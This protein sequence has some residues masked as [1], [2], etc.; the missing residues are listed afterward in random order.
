MSLRKVLQVFVDS[1]SELQHILTHLLGPQVGGGSLT[2]DPPGA[3]H[4]NSFVPEQVQI[5]VHVVGEVTEL[6]DVWS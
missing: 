4:Q 6:S 5:L 2:A 3:V 1:S